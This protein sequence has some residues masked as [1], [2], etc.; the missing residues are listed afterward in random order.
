MACKSD[1]LVAEIDENIVCLPHTSTANIRLTD[2]DFLLFLPVKSTDSWICE[3]IYLGRPQQG[4]PYWTYHALARILNNESVFSRYVTFWREAFEAYVSRNVTNPVYWLTNACGQPVPRPE[5]WPARKTG[6]GYESISDGKTRVGLD[7]TDDIKKGI[8]Q[9]LKIG[10]QTKL[11]ENN[12]NIKVGLLSNIHAARHYAEY[13]MGMENV[14][15]TLDENSSPNSTRYYSSEEMHNLFDG[16]VTF[17]KSHI[18]D[19]WLKNLFDFRGIG[20]V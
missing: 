5:N 2:S 16:I 13:L 7:R 14:I 12:R 10:T 8:Y 11:L 19:S 15:W 6:A 17:T 1:K 20:N 9:V 18:R 4:S 3:T